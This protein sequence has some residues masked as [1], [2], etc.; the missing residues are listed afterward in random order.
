M[1]TGKTEK[2]L[3]QGLPAA[4]GAPRTAT[5]TGERKEHRAGP[6]RGGRQRQRDSCGE[7]TETGLGEEGSAAQ[8]TLWVEGKREARADRKWGLLFY[9]KSSP[10]AGQSGQRRSWTQWGRA[11]IRHLHGLHP[12]PGL[13]LAH[14]HPSRARAQRPSVPGNLRVEGPD[15]F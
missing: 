4:E 8:L 15:L 1:S 7:E 2:E 12:R 11:G 9:R 10:C 14:S 5:G 13:A 3:W 6:E